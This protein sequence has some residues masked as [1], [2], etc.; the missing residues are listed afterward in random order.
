M[1]EKILVCLDGSNLSEQIL[2]FA[3][4]QALKFNS[5]VI[6]FRVVTISSN[7][8]VQAGAT[9]QDAKDHADQ[10]QNDFAK[11]TVYLENVTRSLQAKGIQSQVEVVKAPSVGKAILDYA[12]NNHVDLIA[13]ATHGHSGLGHLVFGNVAEHVLKQ[14]GL[15]MLVI[16]PKN[17]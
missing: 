5:R 14:S 8:I 13:I 17:T 9:Y 11:A 1:F 12:E 3:E 6:L 4:A 2:P 15:P 7:S 10:A 16:R